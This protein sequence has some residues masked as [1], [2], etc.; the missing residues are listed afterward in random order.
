MLCGYLNIIVVIIVYLFHKSI[1]L[2]N[3]ETWHNF[4]FNIV[5]VEKLLNNRL[6]FEVREKKKLKYGG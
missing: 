2:E 5:Y 1:I 6:P 4:L 3:E